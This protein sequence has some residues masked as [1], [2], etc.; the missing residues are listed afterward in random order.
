MT[1]FTINKILLNLDAIGEELKNTREKKRISLEKAS[2]ETGINIKYLKALEEGSAEKLPKGIYG[3]KFLKEYA[4]FL[5]LNVESLI[6][7]YYEEPEGRDKKRDK[8]MFTQ[9]VPRSHYFL[10]LP[11]IIKNTIITLALI[12]CLTY[13]GYSLKNI[14]SPPELSILNPNDNITIEDNFINIQ[15]RTEPGAE[16]I[17]NGEPIL[18]ESDGSFSKELS[19]K[20]GL[21]TVSITAQKKYSRK[22]EQIKT[23]MVKDQNQSG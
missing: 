20:Y 4:S 9:R 6:E 8:A 21:N 23:I 15:G 17:I 12:V 19:L 13:L 7:S 1:S 11:R 16:V 2:S 14:F 5:G 18:I 3:K 10:S 22:N